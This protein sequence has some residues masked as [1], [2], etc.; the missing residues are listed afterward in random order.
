MLMRR[1]K[2]AAWITLILIFSIA[3]ALLSTRPPSPLAAAERLVEAV[4]YHFLGPEGRSASDVVVVGIT[5]ETLSAFPYRSP[6]DRAFL[7]SVIDTLARS[8]VRA[9]GLDVVLD[10]PT[11]PAKDAALRRALTRTDVPVVAISIAPDTT[12]SSTQ[13]RFFGRLPGRRADR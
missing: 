7:A 13:R 5:E 11:E 6:I 8:G 3:A 12:M 4:A 2:A 1:V 10:R 9:V